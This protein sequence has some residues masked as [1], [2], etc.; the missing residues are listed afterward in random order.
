MPVFDNMIEW[1]KKRYAKLVAKFGKA[2][3]DKARKRCRKDCNRTSWG[4]KC[5]MLPLA[6]DGNLCRYFK[7]REHHRCEC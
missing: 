4:R 2:A 5:S 7:H 1:Q 3:M 6:D